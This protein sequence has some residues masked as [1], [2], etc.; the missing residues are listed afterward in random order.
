[1]N[2]LLEEM[3]QDVSLN[4]QLDNLSTSGLKTVSN[5]AAE[6]SN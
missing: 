3:E 6:V 4:T 5:L 2:D 1:M